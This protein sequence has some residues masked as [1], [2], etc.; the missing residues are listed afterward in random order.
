M[1]RS[2]RAAGMSEFSPAMTSV[3]HDLVTI[4]G[5]HLS[6]FCGLIGATQSVGTGVPT[7]TVGTR[8]GRAVRTGWEAH[9][10]EGPAIAKSP[11]RQSA[12]GPSIEFHPGFES[13]LEGR[14]GEA[15]VSRLAVSGR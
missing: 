12:I 13:R 7:E 10:A 14:A 8:A 9:P 15:F 11:G 2:M 1:I 4:Y 5:Y 6:G 3:L